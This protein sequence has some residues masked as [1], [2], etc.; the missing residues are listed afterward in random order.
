MRLISQS[1]DTQFDTYINHLYGSI[2]VTNKQLAFA[3]EQNVKLNV[4]MIMMSKEFKRRD[5]LEHFHSWIIFGTKRDDDRLDKEDAGDDHP[6][7][8]L[9]GYNSETA[10]AFSRS[11]KEAPYVKVPKWKKRRQPY[12]GDINYIIDD[13]S[14]ATMLKSPANFKE[15]FLKNVNDMFGRKYNHSKDL[16]YVRIYYWKTIP[17]Q[18]MLTCNKKTLI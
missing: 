15:G 7:V 5:V 18:M 11:R 14:F 12:K 13:L 10:S 3:K 1:C 17:Y 9:Y 4:D 8:K 6:L 16:V 2:V